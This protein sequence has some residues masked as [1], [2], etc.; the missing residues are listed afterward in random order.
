MCGCRVVTAMV[1][2]GNVRPLVQRDEN[3]KVIIRA[4]VDRFWFDKGA[5][6]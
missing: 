1:G 6:S 2:Y 5:T 4:T 3:I